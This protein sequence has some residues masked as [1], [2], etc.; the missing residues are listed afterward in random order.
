VAV[1]V[2]VRD[3]A[4]PSTVVG[5]LPP[6]PV[7]SRRPEG[8]VDPGRPALGV[9]VRIRKDDVGITVMVDVG[10]VNHLDDTAGIDVQIGTAVLAATTRQLIETAVHPG[11]GKLAVTHSSI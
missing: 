7:A 3:A 4:H 2:H 9:A 5:Q 1:T 8:L 11:V 10:P 6:R